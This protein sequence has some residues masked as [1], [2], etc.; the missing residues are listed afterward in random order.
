MSR[1]APIGAVLVSK[2]SAGDLNI[3]AN[4]REPILT[5]LIDVL[6]KKAASIL[7]RAQLLEQRDCQFHPGRLP[8]A[9]LASFLPIHRAAARCVE[10]DTASAFQPRL[11]S[12][13]QYR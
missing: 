13:G 11:C 7:E 6:Q 1:A 3:P 9:S 10:P 5:R 12:R 8:H 4:D 2:A